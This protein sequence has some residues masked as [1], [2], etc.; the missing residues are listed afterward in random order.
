MQ[1]E[2]RSLRASRI[3]GTTCRGDQCRLRLPGSGSLS[4]EQSDARST[5]VRVR[6]YVE[7]ARQVG[8]RIVQAVVALRVAIEDRLTTKRASERWFAHPTPPSSLLSDPWVGSSSSS[9]RSLKQ[10]SQRIEPNRSKPSVKCRSVQNT[11]S[12]QSAHSARRAR[13]SR[14]RQAPRPRR[15][16]SLPSSRSAGSGAGWP[17]PWGFSVVRC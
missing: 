12:P 4:L 13:R 1:R 9:Q 17:Y 15:R 16:G 10:P 5:Q 3:S 11:S 2:G 8:A 7:P 6:G 14:L